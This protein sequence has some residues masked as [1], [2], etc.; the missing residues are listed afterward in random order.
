MLSI[1]L[2]L[3]L[4]SVLFPPVF[5]TNNLLINLYIL[6][7]I[8]YYR[9]GGSAAVKDLGYKQEGRGFGPDEVNY[10]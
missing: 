7:Q 9:A 3:G 1:H 8:H 4:P 2:R 5:P 6:N 10:I